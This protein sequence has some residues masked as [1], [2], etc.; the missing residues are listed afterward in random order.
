MRKVICSHCKAVNKVDSKAEFYYCNSCGKKEQISVEDKKKKPT[1]IILMVLSGLIAITLFVFIPV[2]Q[3]NKVIK[4]SE[5]KEK[6]SSLKE[7]NLSDIVRKKLF[8]FI[9][10]EIEGN[11]DYI[12]I[13]DNYKVNVKQFGSNKEFIFEVVDDL[14]PDIISEEIKLAYL[15]NINYDD[16]I[17][18]VDYVDGDVSLT[19]ENVKI[20]TSNV[21]INEEGIY[22]IT[23]EVKDKYGNE[24]KKTIKTVVEKQKPSS[25][26]LNLK[27]SYEVNKTIELSSTMKPDNTF[28][29]NVIWTV[30]GKTLTD[31]K[32]KPTK[33]GD[34]RICATS[35]MDENIKSCKEV[36]INNACK[37][38]Y[39]FTLNG[40]SA[41]T[42]EVSKQG[43]IC[44]GKYRIS[45]S[46][47][48]STTSAALT[49]N[50]FGSF[51]GSNDMIM[52][53]AGMFSGSGKKYVI[54]DGAYL[55]AD[56]GITKVTLVKV[57]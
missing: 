12:G 34:I 19:S 7:C 14:A 16:Q 50:Y 35:V 27:S 51:Y 56:P 10:Y 57:K 21:N 48:N 31:N 44:P 42:Y 4:T 18:I 39:V 37:S 55:E 45:V 29:K 24:N 40:G 25:I 49:I 15:G 20:D 1:K 41:A 13:T 54:N 43:D 6:C 17:T 11:V 9:K 47:I 32:Y 5:I 3:Y 33:A 26:A 2:R 23:V 30:E 46:A 28:D 8:S 52:P 53:A 22:S 36:A 38:K